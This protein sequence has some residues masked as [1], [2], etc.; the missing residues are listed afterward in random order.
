MLE[1]N[2]KTCLYVAMRELHC[3]YALKL[4]S[5]S[6]A[7]QNLTIFVYVYMYIIWSLKTYYTKTAK[8]MHDWSWVSLI[9]YYPIRLLVLL[10]NH[11][12]SSLYWFK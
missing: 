2:L 7:Y 8:T 6:L 5:A 3:V 12:Y 4:L 9:I 1:F 10:L 11:V